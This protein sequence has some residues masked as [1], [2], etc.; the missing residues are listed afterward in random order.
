[1]IRCE[2]E[3]KNIGAMTNISPPRSGGGMLVIG[4]E[5]VSK[6]CQDCN[7]DGE[8]WNTTDDGRPLRHCAQCDWVSKKNST[9]KHAAYE[10]ATRHLGRR[11]PSAGV[12]RERWGFG[13]FGV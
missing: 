4:H 12:E 7:T 1:M 2:T 9:R 5:K 10:I 3:A 8:V 6:A 13:V 11:A